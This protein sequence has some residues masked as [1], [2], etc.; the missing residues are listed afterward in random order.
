[1]RRDPLD[2][3][4]QATPSTIGGLVSEALGSAVSFKS[5]D[6]LGLSHHPEVIK[7]SAR[8][9]EE[10]GFGSGAA[11]AEAAGTS[12]F[13]ELERRLAGFRGVEAVLT[14]QTGYMANLGVM[15]SICGPSD[16]VVYDE[17]SHPSIED[18]V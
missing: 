2:Y 1:M 13:E 16:V 4:L 15:T 17:L 9:L 5:K 3:P 10:D 8:A 14:F 6:Y 18:A 11:R 12:R 7:A